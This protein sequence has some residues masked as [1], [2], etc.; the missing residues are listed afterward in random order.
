M[1]PIRAS[2]VTRPP[3]V[4]MILAS[5]TRRPII[6]SGSIRESMQVT[7]ATPAWAMPS[8]PPWENCIW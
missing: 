4:R 8:K 1:Q 6:S 7:M 5:P 2:G 3:G